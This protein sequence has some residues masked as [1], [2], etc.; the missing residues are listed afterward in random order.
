[1]SPRGRA[2]LGV[3]LVAIVLLTFGRSAVFDFLTWD[4]GLNVYKNELLNPPTGG[5]L[6]DLWRQPNLELYIP[7]PYTAWWTI[8]KF[9]H[10]DFPDEQGSQLNPWLFHAAN[11]AVHAL[12]VLAV[13]GFLRRLLAKTG[14]D[15]TWPAFV[16]AALFAIHPIQ[17]EAVAWVTGMR[18]LLAGLFAVIALW[19]YTLAASGRRACWFGAAVAFAAALLSKPAAVVLPVMAMAVDVWLVG[20]PWR[21]AIVPAAIGLV[22]LALPAV[23]VTHL[24]QHTEVSTPGPIYNR[25][26]VAGDSM[27]FYLRQLIWP[28]HL[29][30]DYGRRPAK[31]LGHA[32]VYAELVVPIVV[33]AAAWVARRRWPAV[34]VATVWFFVAL[35]PTSGIVPFNFQYFSTVTDHYAYLAM[36]GPALVAA[37]VMSRT[38]GVPSRAIAAVIFVALAARSVVQVGTWR[39]NA[40]LWRHVAELN[41]GDFAAETELGMADVDQQRELFKQGRTAEARAASERAVARFRRALADYPLHGIAR[42][43]L[44]TQ[45]AILGDWDAA[46]ADARELVRTARVQPIEHAK[47]YVQVLELL[48]QGAEQR[49]DTADAKLFREE[50]ARITAGR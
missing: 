48:A 5:H 37:V 50:V 10:V 2:G 29:S 3:L 40:T 41:P 22:C 35:L 30:S 38:G 34:W 23:Y 17:V 27:T 49:G 39:D 9:A 18:D 46:F 8:A 31:V 13:F 43:H 7:L 45:E 11:I 26:L 6:W 21:K 28:A 44:A 20:R 47:G 16:G 4:D 12:T 36:L 42:K 32:W 1:M 19:Q 25:L 14:R 33:L 15:P 24:A